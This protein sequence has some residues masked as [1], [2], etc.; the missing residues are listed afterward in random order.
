MEAVLIHIPCV[1][2]SGIL[3]SLRAQELRRGP[4]EVWAQHSGW[5]E[6]WA[7]EPGFPGGPH[8]NHLTGDTERDTERS[9]SFFAVPETNSLNVAPTHPAVKLKSLPVS[10]QYR[11]LALSSFFF[12]N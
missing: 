9:R 2:E 4:G 10:S 3:V 12:L 8:P 6:M 11:C 1:S 7:L 5:S